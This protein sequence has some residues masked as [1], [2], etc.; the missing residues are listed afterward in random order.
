MLQLNQK[1]GQIYD[2]QTG[3]TVAIMLDKADPTIAALFASAPEL[4]AALEAMASLCGGDL[5]RSCGTQTVNG[6]RIKA[7]LEQARAAISKATGE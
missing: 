5:L 3:K 1:D 6:Q 4:L 2:V 7:R